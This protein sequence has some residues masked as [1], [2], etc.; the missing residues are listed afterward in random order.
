MQ[1]DTCLTVIEEAEVLTRDDIE[2]VYG[3][4]E[5]LRGTAVLLEFNLAS[6]LAEVEWR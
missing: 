5:I 6:E 2:T 3:K 4:P 1:H